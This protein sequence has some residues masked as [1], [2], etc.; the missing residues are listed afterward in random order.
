MTVAA[1]AS[2][3]PGPGQIFLDHVGHFVADVEAAD[4]ALRQAGFAPT[5]VSMQVNPDPAGGAPKPTGTGNV[6]AMFEAGYVE[7]LFKT[8]DTPLGAEFDAARAR[9]SGLHLVAFAIPDADAEHA[10]LA[11]A[12][13][14]MQPVVRMQRPVDTET[15]DTETGDDIAAFEVVRLVP[16]QMPEG[17]IQVLRHKTEDT[18][19]Q[20]RWLTHPNGACALE[21]LTIVVADVAEAS[22]RFQ[23]F[24]GRPHAPLDAKS[25]DGGQRIGLDR[26]V[27]ELIDI[28][29]WGKRWLDV[30]VPNRLVTSLPFMGASL[31]FMGECRI[32]VNG[33]TDL[34]RRVAN[35][36]LKQLRRDPRH[37]SVAFP[38]AL[39]LGVWTF[40]AP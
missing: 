20:P 26:G 23:R 3:L 33:L 35:G 7:V 25:I 34:D 10:R 37:L 6:C 36:D 30:T 17:R 8:A 1:N 9:Y 21:A 11:A 12:G 38:P 19:W 24:T 40:V 5:P 29:E 16:G 13:F 2:Q 15:G 14:A 28:Q 4:A 22:N 27:L 18:V 39:G 31:P 32:A